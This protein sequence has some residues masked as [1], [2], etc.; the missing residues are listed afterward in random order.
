MQLNKAKP[1]EYIRNE[2][3]GGNPLFHLSL[4]TGFHYLHKHLRRQ[5]KRETDEMVS[6]R[7]LCR[8]LLWRLASNKL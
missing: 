8:R 6:H 4:H 3:K 2:K 5:P 1:G 7:N